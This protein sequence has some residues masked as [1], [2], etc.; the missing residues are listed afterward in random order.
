MDLTLLQSRPF[1]S[2][3]SSLYPVTEQPTPAFPKRFSDYGVR[4]VFLRLPHFNSVPCQTLILAST[5]QW[6]FSPVMKAG[7]NNLVLRFC[8]VMAAAMTRHEE[9]Q[10]GQ[11]AQ[12]RPIDSRQQP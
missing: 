10:Y 1:F 2:G 9:L 12:S 3:T 7:L 8:R 4:E 5:Q 6:V 11:E